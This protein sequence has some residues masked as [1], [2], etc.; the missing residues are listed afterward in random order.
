MD[1]LT[2]IPFQRLVLCVCGVYMPFPETGH[3]WWCM[4]M[5]VH[6]PFLRHM[7]VCEHLVY[8]T[9]LSPVTRGIEHGH[10][11]VVFQLQTFPKPVSLGRCV[12]MLAH[13]L[14][15]SPVNI[16]LS[17]CMPH[18]SQSALRPCMG[19]LDNK[20]VLS[21]VAPGWSVG[22]L[23]HAPFPSCVSWEIGTCTLAHM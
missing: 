17:A 19:M 10:L 2:L 11:V 12:S 1:V 3:M 21:P 6:T 23:A 18:L 14:F 5:L 20:P 13:M 9:F 22:I 16:C 7:L 4:N 15:P 8:D